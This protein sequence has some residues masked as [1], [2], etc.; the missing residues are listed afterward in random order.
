MLKADEMFFE[1][2]VEAIYL[3]M[4]ALHVGY[5]LSTRA[6]PSDWINKFKRKFAKYIQQKHDTFDK[7]Y[8]THLDP[9]KSSTW[10]IDISVNG[11]MVER[12]K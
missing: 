4:K 3:Y 1:K 7:E 9:F 11:K 6:H 12:L 2:P 5:Y 10:N 8:F